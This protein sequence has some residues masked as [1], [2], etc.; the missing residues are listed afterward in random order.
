M[1]L[2]HLHIQ[3]FRC[4]EDAHFDFQPGFNLVVGVNGSGKTSLLNAVARCFAGLGEEF[5]SLAQ[6]VP[7][8]DIRFVIKN[9]NGRITSE[10]CFPTKI[11][12]EGEAF[13]L[14]EWHVQINGLNDTSLPNSSNLTVLAANDAPVLAYYRANRR[15]NGVGVT[16]EFA[17]QYRVFRLTGYLNWA[18]AVVDLKDF[19]GWL[20]GRTLLRLQYLLDAKTA[21]KSLDDELS[22]INDAI[23]VALP[24]AGN[25]RYDLRLQQLLVDVDEGKTIPFNDLSD[26]QR[27]LIAL[28]AD[29]ARRMCILN[30][31]M[32]KDVLKNTSGVVIIDELDIHLHPAWQ[33]TIVHALKSAFPKVQFIAASHS[34]QIIGSLRP[35]E[36]IVLDNGDSSHPRA[37]YGLDSSRVLEEVM[38]APQ[39][40]PKVESLLSELFSALESNNLEEAKTRLSSLKAEAPDLPEFAR[41]EAL[42]KRKEVLG[43]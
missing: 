15:W 2:D 39:R 27:G 25:L 32:G 31:H 14:S 36:I 40:E 42:L 1:R 8:Q 38:G 28:I 43:K 11:T 5:S 26:G 33:R 16:A 12:A 9:V 34:P 17:A 7:E 41:A 37:S 35:E 19:E 23:R 22:I 20:I 29:I 6:S 3:N 18:D 30:P 10:H 4:Y 24:Q 21:V 13:G